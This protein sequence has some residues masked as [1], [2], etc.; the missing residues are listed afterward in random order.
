MRNMRP[1]VLFLAGLCVL[2]TSMTAQTKAIQ[3]TSALSKRAWRAAPPAE[4]EAVL[5]ARATVEKE[6]IETELRTAT[7]VID[8]RGRVFAAVVLIT[9]GYAANGKYSHYLLAQTP[10]RIGADIVLPSGAYAVGWTRSPDGLLVHIY[11]AET[12]AE[13]G[14]ITAHPAAQPIPIV[15]IK[16]WP[17]RERSVIQIGRFLLPYSLD[18]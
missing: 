18:E 5:P 16:I 14:T 12:G 4:L 2:P 7:G 15:S 9:A 1:C 17:P 6:R 10:V 8:S 11:N 3:A 13:L